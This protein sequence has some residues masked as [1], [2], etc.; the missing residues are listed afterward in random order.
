[1]ADTRTADPPYVGR[2]VLKIDGRTVGSF[3]EVSGLSVQVDVED[4]VEGGR[5]HYVHHLPKGMKWPNL[6]LKRGITDTDSL[7]EW[8]WRSSGD[9]LTAN[10]NTLELVSGSLAVLDA[11]KHPVRTWHFAGAYPVKWTGPTLAAS[12]SALAVEQLEICHRGFRSKL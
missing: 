9:G 6:V 8:L 4:V 5:N 1:V 10:D 3:M 12:S 2:F 11:S 7:F